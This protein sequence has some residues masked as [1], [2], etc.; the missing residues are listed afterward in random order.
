MTISGYSKTSRVGLLAASTAAASLVLAPSNEAKADHPI[1][2]AGIGA[3]A[4]IAGSLITGAATIAGAVIVVIGT[5]GGG[6]D[7][8]DDGETIV[9][10]TDENG[11]IISNKSR[12]EN[13]NGDTIPVENEMVAVEGVLGA[14]Q[15]ASTGQSGVDPLFQSYVSRSASIGLR[16]VSPQHGLGVN[17]SYSLDG[18][19]L[20]SPQNVQRFLNGDKAIYSFQLEGPG[21]LPFQFKNLMLKTHDEP[22][23]FGYSAL[24]MV[25]RQH[26]QKIMEW[27]ASVQQ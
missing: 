17:V 4:V 13:N 24:V 22:G 2:V 14:N 26:G 18:N 27:T 10:G 15:M 25:A 21:R 19:V 11:N 3:G 12:Q 7:D 9:P 5:S 8:D 16:T 6:D 23:S 20:N 1:L